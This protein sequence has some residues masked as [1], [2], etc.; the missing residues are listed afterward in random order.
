[1]NTTPST[2][3]KF[4]GVYLDPRYL[5]E[6]NWDV[7]KVLRTVKEEMG[8]DNVFFRLYAYNVGQADTRRLLHFHPRKEFY[9]NTR[10]KPVPPDDLPFDPMEKLC[11]EAARL[12]LG[13]HAYI[14]PSKETPHQLENYPAGLEVDLEGNAG[15][16]V[17]FGNPDYVEHLVSVARDI[18]D[19][20]PIRGAMYGS[21]RGGPLFMFLKTSDAPVCFCDH[22]LATARNRGMDPEN[23][24]EGFRKLQSLFGD[25]RRGGQNTVR[26][27]PSVFRPTRPPE[28]F[29]V[30]FLR[31]LFRHPE[32][33]FWNHLWHENQLNLQRRLYHTFKE[34]GERSVGW[35][36]WHRGRAF[37]P[38][39]RAEEDF[40]DLIEISDF[41][42]PSAFRNATGNRF[43]EEAVSLNETIF[44]DLD[45]DEVA[46][47]LYKFCGYENEGTTGGIKD[48][49]FSNRYMR[50]EMEMAMAK[51]AGRTKVY[52]GI[53]AYHYS[54]WT[55]RPAEG[56]HVKEDI[57]AAVEAG[58]DGLLF[59]SIDYDE[60]AG[61]V[62]E[63]LREI[64]WR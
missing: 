34:S 30:E 62:G 45:L 46:R 54:N 4:T 26:N 27:H 10:I 14:F 35:H 12:D 51:I 57:H 7:A 23:A 63:G 43:I 32:L 36:M 16:R 17:C 58:V 6:K 9:E 40:E 38:L 28:G 21:E 2:G 24:R 60:F 39:M 33:L 55:P 59:G 19:H 15:K 41:I 13:I 37:S 1:M 53:S 18:S 49:P 8:V 61:A 44:A 47:M 3:D 42:K 22:C 50:R 20:Y 25:H 64:G 52:A 48:H 11:E 29:F 31:I 5:E 56:R